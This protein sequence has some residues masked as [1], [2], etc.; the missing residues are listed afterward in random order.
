LNTSAQPK[1]SI[2]SADQ[3]NEM[4]IDAIRDIKGKHI[5][6]LDLRN[7]NDAPVDF[8]IICEGESTTQVRG[9]S[10]SIIRKIKELAGIFP[11]HVEG[12]KQAQWI[13]VDYFNVVVHVFHP[14]AR[15]FYELEELW[16]DAKTTE[17]EDL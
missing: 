8:F 1:A 11:S 15:N 9:I 13:L 14:E 12:S 5:L 6:K 7:L 3:F 17:Y 10:E 2:I 16:N 4:I